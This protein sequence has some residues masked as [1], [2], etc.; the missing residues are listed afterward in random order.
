MRGLEL[1]MVRERN[2]ME[3][4]NTKDGESQYLSYLISGASKTGKTVLSTTVP[5]NQL[6]LCNIEN[7][8]ASIYGADVNKVDCPDYSA[9]VE[10][11]DWLEAI[12][13]GFEAKA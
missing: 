3:F 6:L 2:K 11:V 10:V 12:W 7:N 8:L 1:R 13:K 4:S 9:V 5:S